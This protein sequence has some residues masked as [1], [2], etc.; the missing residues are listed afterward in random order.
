MT[1]LYPSEHFI[2]DNTSGA[3]N[4]SFTT[5]AERAKTQGYTTGAFI[6][7]YVLDHSRGLDQGFDTYFDNFHPQDI[8]KASQVSDVERPARD[9]VQ[10]ALT[11]WENTQGPRFAWVHLFDAHRPYEPPFGWTGDPYRGELFAMDRALQPLLATVPENTGI[12]VVADHG[13]N[14]WDGGELEH[15]VLLTRSVLRVPLMIRPPSGVPNGTPVAAKPPPE[16]P[17]DWRPVPGI[18]PE[19]FDLNAVPDAPRAAHVIESPVSV[20]DIYPTL[21]T[22]L[23]SPCT[24]CPGQDLNRSTDGSGLSDRP[25]YAETV[26]PYRHFG[27]SPIFV[28][29][30]ETH[31]LRETD[32]QY[33]YS[34]PKDPYWLHPLDNADTTHLNTQ[35]SSLKKGWR[36][37]TEG[38]DEQ[39]RLQL[40]QLGYA[41]HTVHADAGPLS[42]PESKMG[43]LNQIYLA[44]GM[45]KSKPNEA[46]DTLLAVVDKE[47]NLIDAQFSLASIAVAQQDGPTALVHLDAVL[48]TAPT[49]TQ[50]LELKAFVLPKFETI[51]RVGNRAATADSAPS[52]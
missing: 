51:R 52:Q 11:W 2:R 1:G 39:T 16:R 47:P 13:E 10:E 50:A 18:G 12:V 49:H 46:R 37:A 24:D 28:S 31:V 41:T 42:D 48:K 34:L 33:L 45:M 29:I 32:T 27:W 14:L 17:S 3:L 21:S 26:Y 38:V 35:I 25:I 5:I 19:N 9:V 15:G 6:G 20:I 7:A 22:W 4:P 44:Q 30:D 43:V 40:E 23:Q 8:A 36:D